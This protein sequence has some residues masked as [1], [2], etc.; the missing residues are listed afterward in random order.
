MIHACKHN[1]R[2]KT[3][4]KHTHAQH[5]HNT[6]TTHT[7]HTHDMHKRQLVFGVTIVTGSVVLITT[8]ILIVYGVTNVRPTVSKD[9]WLFSDGSSSATLSNNQTSK[10][11]YFAAALFTMQEII[12]N[13]LVCRAIVEESNGQYTCVL[14][15]HQLVELQ[16]LD[17][18]AIRNSD[19]NL[20]LSTDVVL[21]NFNGLE[22]DSG[23]VVEFMVSKFAD[24]P[25]VI[26]RTD[27]RRPEEF[28]NLMAS[29]W[30]RTEIVTLDAAQLYHLE[31]MR[32]PEQ[33][34]KQVA[35]RLVQAINRALNLPPTTI[36]TTQ[37]TLAHNWLNRLIH[38]TG[39]GPGPI[40]Q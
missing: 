5:T 2:Q 24:L 3:H 4:S 13:D 32:D 37:R 36:D 21:L 7:Q 30:P 14:P 28:W 15:Q 40:T 38:T 23:V 11:I 22:L 6:H 31:A 8:C 26:L 16:H 27:F 19:L 33:F 39:P 25:A 35:I 29:F 18:L 17:Q 10:R 12:G 20:L 34:A 9:S 1:C